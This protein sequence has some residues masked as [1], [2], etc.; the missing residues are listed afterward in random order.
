MQVGDA[1]SHVQN[2]EVDPRPLV[3]VNDFG[4]CSCLNFVVSKLEEIASGLCYLHG[5]DPQIF[6]GDLKGVRVLA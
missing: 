3:S 6:H 1:F 5:H 4:L 2:K